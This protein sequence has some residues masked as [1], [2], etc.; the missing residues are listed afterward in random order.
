LRRRR[1]ADTILARRPRL[2]AATCPR[3]AFVAIM[4]WLAGPHARVF[5]TG[6][7]PGSTAL[8]L[9]AA[10]AETVAFQ[11]AVSYTR[12]G[13]SDPETVEVSAS[14][15]AGPLGTPRIRLVGYVP[16]PHHNTDTPE[17]E[18]DCRGHI[19]G[20]VPDPLLDRTAT[21]VASC[22]LPLPVAQ[23]PPGGHSPFSPV[24]VH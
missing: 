20:Y 13:A 14:C 9:D 19:P 18:L 4:T 1:R 15:A 24:E 12:R 10:R 21:R 6:N 11:V 23:T 3:E 17:D 7:V 16:V 2:Q 22:C 5:P 8:E